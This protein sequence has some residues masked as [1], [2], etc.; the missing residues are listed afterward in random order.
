M[1]D[2]KY[3]L[4]NLEDVQKRLNQKGGIQDLGPLLLL[5]QRRRDLQ[6]EYDD[7]RHR[8]NEVSQEIA[9]KKKKRESA[10]V[11]MGEMKE[12]AHRVK[13]LGPELSQVESQIKDYLLTIPNLPHSSVPVGT[14]EKGNQEIRKWGKPP[15]FDFQ[16]RTHDV[17]GEALGILDF[18]RAVKI[19]GARF[20]LSRGAGAL[21][22]RALINFMLDCHTKEHGYLEILPPFMV[23]RRS[24]IGTGQLPKFEEDLFK[25]DYKDREDKKFS[26]EDE[27]FLIPT[28]EVPVTNIHREEILDGDKLPLKYVAHT[29][30]FRSEAG[31]YGKD[32]KGL[33]RLHQFN[34]VE[35]VHYVA[36]DTSYEALESLTRHA[37]SILQK[38]GLPYRVVSLCTGDLG[39]GASKTYDL[40][41][42][43]AGEKTYREI[44]SCSNY[45]DYQ[46]R[47]MNIRYRA[48]SKD[49]PQFVHTLNG[50]GLAV[51]RT[52]AA[53]LENY[54][55]A[56]GSVL[57]PPIL[58]SYMHGLKKMSVVPL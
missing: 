16:P 52:V 32:T 50:S 26:K 5:D 30:C 47:R 48:A 39:F 44:S 17:I 37:E 55:Q 13:I 8:Q 25:I 53:L 58:Q 6:K 14:G 22:E 4:Q 51:G 3:V 24:L 31:S 40:E 11:L 33:I 57:I 56:D 19:S 34:K 36:A 15:S 35:L 21:L 46:A 12:V 43:M 42:W 18:E 10:E 7:L 41:V 27:L 23:A 45:E 9:L 29:P 38:L 28:A 1:L 54:Q 20:A 2:L 49:K